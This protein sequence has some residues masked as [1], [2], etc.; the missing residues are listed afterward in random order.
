M[1]K[2]FCHYFLSLFSSFIER[3]RYTIIAT[4]KRRVTYNESKLLLIVGFDYDFLLVPWFDIWIEKKIE[5]VVDAALYSVQQRN[6]RPFCGS[7]TFYFMLSLF[8]AKNMDCLSKS[9][10]MNPL[11]RPLS[12]HMG[13]FVTQNRK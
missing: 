8:F 9:N 10:T 2:F 6:A 11:P 13:A 3:A 12:Y 4:K 5:A 1:E 7:L